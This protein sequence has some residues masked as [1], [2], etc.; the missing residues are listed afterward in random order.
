MRR[1]ACC[2]LV[3]FVMSGCAAPKPAAPST[4]WGAC[5]YD[6]VAAQLQ[7]PVQEQLKLP[8]ERRPRDSGV[9]ILDY[10][11]ACLAAGDADGAQQAFYQAI[12]VTNDF[13]LGE[14]AGNTSL[15]FSES[16]KVWQGEAFE[17]AMI[18]LLHGIALIQQGDFDNA[19][20]AFDRAIAADRYSRGGVAEIEGYAATPPEAK[21]T[22]VQVFN[23]NDACHNG[24]G[25]VVCRDFLAAYILRTMCFLHLNRLRQARQSWAETGKV[26]DDLCR[27]T[28]AS[29]AGVNH[30]DVWTGDEGRY[31][32]P[33]VYLPPFRA[34]NRVRKQI[35]A[36]SLEDLRRANV[37]I[38]AA[39]GSR[40]KKVRTGTVT[41]QSVKFVHDGFLPPSE[42]ITDFAVVIDGERRGEM[43]QCLN[44]YGQVAGRG[45][46]LKDAAQEHKRK[47]ED[48]GEALE[49]SGND[50]LKLIGSIVRAV[51]QEEADV[52]QWR[53]LPNSIHLWLGRI[54]PGVHTLRL[55]PEGANVAATESPVDTIFAGYIQ[56]SEVAYAR[57]VLGNWRMGQS[58]PYA[59]RHALARSLVVPET[60]LTTLFIPEQFNEQVRVAAPAPPR[61][62]ELL[63]RMKPGQQ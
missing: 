2:G 52:R 19:R 38:I 11:A 30:T 55:L 44:M 49:N 12:L 1:F 14:S 20:V 18:E 5:R 42:S 16:A 39:T 58:M 21:N 10:A 48:V 62:Y 7:K 37:L 29:G 41:G 27:V 24:G 63:P 40:P 13:T 15:V 3:L 60:G 51:N 23:E 47:V 6:R 22:G 8:A 56:A 46:S 34:A 9:T 53:L 17:R 57:G 50:Y 61:S 45:P 4:T 43:V 32:F 54:E 26:F 36:Q 28:E 31:S 35:V 33:K 59:A 25:T